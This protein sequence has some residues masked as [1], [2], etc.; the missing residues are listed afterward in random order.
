MQIQCQHMVTSKQHTP[1]AL[2][3]EV[4]PIYICVVAHSSAGIHF[5]FP[6]SYITGIIRP[7]TIY[8]SHPIFK[9]QHMCLYDCDKR[10]AK[11]SELFS[12]LIILT[13]IYYLFISP[14]QP[15][16][17]SKGLIQSL[18]PSRMKG[19]LPRIQSL[20]ENNDGESNHRL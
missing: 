18:L 8:C 14:T 15:I 3:L 17:E 2:I 10:I 13:F 7:G 9:S 12:G 5:N 16:S 11:S 1:H 4:Y 20:A 6:F 19:P